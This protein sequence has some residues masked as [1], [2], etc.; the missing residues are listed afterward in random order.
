MAK[1]EVTWS[2]EMYRIYGMP[3][4]APLGGYQGFLSRVYPPNR[5]RTIACTP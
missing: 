3:I 4:G 1:D 5:P 2:D